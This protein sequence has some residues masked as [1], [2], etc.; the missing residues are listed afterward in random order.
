M[1]KFLEKI[2]PLQFQ[3]DKLSEV[4]IFGAGGD[5]W[6]T[7]RLLE[8][9]GIKV[10]AFCDNNISYEGGIIFRTFHQRNYENYQMQ[11]L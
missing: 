4:I 8:Q 6:R 1:K 2:I 9:Y 7:K 11:K 10:K 3:Q 5:G